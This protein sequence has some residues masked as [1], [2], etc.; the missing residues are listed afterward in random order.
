MHGPASDAAAVRP[1][2]AAEIALSQTI[3]GDAID[4]A[5]VEI[6]NRKWVF[7]QPRRVTMA[8]MGHIHF[9]PAGDLYCDD[10][11]DA[12]L[13]RQGLLIHELVHVWQAQTR[14]R[15][16]LVLMRLPGSRYD[17]TLRPG[18]TLTRYGLEQQAEIVRHYFLMT[19]GHLIPGAPDIAA[20]RAILPFGPGR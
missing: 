5:K 6:R 1:M 7:F 19:R 10:F 15:W 18:W 20:Y 9:H 8:P 11:C 4:Y 13:S 3:F 17:Y 16:Y 12:P 14:G 2:T